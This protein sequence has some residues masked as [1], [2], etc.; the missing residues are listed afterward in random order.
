[1]APMT[2]TIVRKSFLSAAAGAA[3]SLGG[4]LSMVLVA[5]TLGVAETG[6]IAYA[7][8]AASI[9]VTVLDFG[10][11]STLARYLPQLVAEQDAER[12]DALT[13]ALFRPYVATGL[14]AV[15][16]IGAYAAWLHAHV[17]DDEQALRLAL[18]AALIGLQAMANFAMGHLRGMQ[19]ASTPWRRSP[20]ARWPCKS[21]AWASAAIS[22]AAPASLPAIAPEARRSPFTRSTGSGGVEST[23]G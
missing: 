16:G 2:G 10:V 18:V 21:P 7:L 9:V 19:R 12:A 15:C 22:G 11:H 23:C 3:T 17:G 14:V 13:A 5:R 20:F 6:A 8:W 4:F 1:M